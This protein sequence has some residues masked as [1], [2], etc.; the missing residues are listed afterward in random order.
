[1]L[2]YRTLFFY[3]HDD[4]ELKLS[5]LVLMSCNI[6]NF[7]FI[8]LVFLASFEIFFNNNGKLTD[9]LGCFYNCGIGY[10][11]HAL[12]TK[13]KKLNLFYIDNLFSKGSRLYFNPIFI[14]N[15]KL[16]KKIN[17]NIFFFKK[18]L[19][20]ENSRNYSIFRSNIPTSLHKNRKEPWASFAK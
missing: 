13:P 3:F 9:F 2:W 18:I 7:F 5:P 11:Y 8:D 15:Q 17:W 10:M 1:M 19:L 12:K 16:L 4:L 14:S 6:Q 20:M